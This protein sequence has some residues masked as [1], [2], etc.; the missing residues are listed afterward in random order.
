MMD[1]QSH[2]ARLADQVMSYGGQS[3]GEEDTKKSSARS[4][5][6]ARGGGGRGGGV[7]GTRGRGSN[8]TSTGSRYV[9]RLCHSTVICSLVRPMD[10]HRIKR[11]PDLKLGNH[12][13]TPP[14]QPRR[15]LDPA[16]QPEPKV[17]ET[18]SRSRR[19]QADSP[20]E[21]KKNHQPNKKDNR[22]NKAPTTRRPVYQA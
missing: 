2:R 9:S 17:Y 10:Q 1:G 21:E 3:Y 11:V 14:T 8:T 7:M 15:R 22:P 20:Q 13:V 5:R 16:L 18:R 4:S 6:G 12:A 19:G